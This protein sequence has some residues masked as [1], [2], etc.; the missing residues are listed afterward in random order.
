MR[1]PAIGPA[2]DVT[3]YLEPDDE[4]IAVR[5]GAL[6]LGAVHFVIRLPPLGL[7]ADSL[8]PLHPGRH[9]CS[10]MRLD[11]DDAGAVQGI[12]RL[13]RLSLAAQLDQ[14]FPDFKRLVHV[15]LLSSFLPERSQSLGGSAENVLSMCNDLI[16][17]R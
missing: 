13:H 10:A 11:A 15:K 12:D 1:L 16:V 9:L 8:Q 6:R 5:P 3:S 14:S 7:T 2:F 17:E 4:P